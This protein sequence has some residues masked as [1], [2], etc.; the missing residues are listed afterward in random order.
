MQDEISNQIMNKLNKILNVMGFNSMLMGT[1][2]LKEAIIGIIENP[3]YL[4]SLNS[5]VL[6]NLS[7][8]F[9]NSIKTIERDIK[10]SITQTLK[11]SNYEQFCKL[12][13]LENKVLTTKQ[14]IILI[15]DLIL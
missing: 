11:T 6:K 9:S 12:F 15:T 5:T 4:I 1:K 2:Y 10:W 14:M 13:C 3:E 8:N 7:L